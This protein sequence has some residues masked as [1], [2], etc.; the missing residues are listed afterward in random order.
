MSMD[1]MTFIIGLSI[2]LAAGGFVAALIVRSRVQQHMNDKLTELEGRA[3]Y[4]EGCSDRLTAQLAGSE[5]EM[6]ALRDE[7]AA[8]K[9]REAE[10]RTR[11]EESHIRLEEQKGLIALMRTEMVETFRAHASSALETSNQNFLQLAEEN[12]GKI[13]EQTKGRMGEHHSAM[14]GIIR[15]LQDVLK[16]Y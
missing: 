3:R 15:P 1:V 10:M 5:K 8:E 2:G 11:L 6:A 4:T 7:L 12:L 14:E 13:M 16:R 9:K